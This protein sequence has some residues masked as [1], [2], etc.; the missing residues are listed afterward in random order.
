MKPELFQAFKS[1][2]TDQQLICFPYLGGNANVFQGVATKISKKIDIIAANLPGHGTF[3]GELIHDINS[4]IDLQY[5]ALKKMIKS[6]TVFFGHSM[7][8]ITAY[9]LAQRIFNSDEYPSKPKAL[10]LSACSYPSSFHMKNY[11]N[12]SDADILHYLSAYEGIPE[13]VMKEKELLNYLLP[14]FRAD[15]DIL[16]SS[17]KCD[18]RPLDIPVYYLWGEND[19]TVPIDSVNQWLKYFKS[20]M[21]LITIEQGSHMFIHQQEDIVT[22]KLEEILTHLKIV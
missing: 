21:N 16:E 17:S 14:I 20:P 15:F 6:K 10:I 8:A 12:W 2:N 22:K 11:S 4:L 3:P 7:G 13:E 1:S 18:Y 19:K 9:F 5:D